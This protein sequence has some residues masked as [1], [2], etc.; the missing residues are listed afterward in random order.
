LAFTLVGLV[1]FSPI[2]RIAL[3]WLYPAKAGLQY[4]LLPCRLDGLA[5]GALIAVRFR[6]GPWELSKRKLTVMA[7]G[8]MAMTCGLG[9]WSGYDFSRPFNRTIGYLISSIACA[10]VVLWLI[11]FRGSRLTAPLRLPPVQHLSKIS[12]AAYLFHMP[13]AGVLL[14]IS[15]AL[16]VGALAHGYLKVVTVFVLTVGLASLSWRFF[17]SPLLGLKDRLFPPQIP[18]NAGSHVVV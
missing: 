10:Y 9:A 4:V 1:C 17:E 5:L 18:R 8:L 6:M 7:V 11:R 14:P 12:Y 16:G 15:A 13:I 3:Y 2:L